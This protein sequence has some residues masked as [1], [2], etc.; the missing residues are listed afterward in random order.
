MVNGKQKGAA[1]EREC[2]KKLSLWLSKGQRDDLLWRSAMSGGR[3]T[4]A[5]ARGRQAANQAGDIS[6]VSAF[7]AVLVDRFVIECKAYRDLNMFGL[8]TG[9]G[10]LCD[11]WEILR[12][13]AEE[14][15]KNPML[16]AKQN[17]RPVI[18]L[19]DDRGTSLLRAKGFVLV[20]VPRLHMNVLLFEDFLKLAPTDFA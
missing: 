14:A 12:S 1:F 18:L 5:L 8:L 7:G 10:N 19:L 4:I 20:N 16:I 11:F 17:Q 2:C 13:Q 3:A 15:K 9:R 6:T